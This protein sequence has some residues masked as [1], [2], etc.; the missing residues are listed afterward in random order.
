MVIMLFLMGRE[1]IVKLNNTLLLG[2][3]SLTSRDLKQAYMKY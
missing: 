3:R 1:I 2:S